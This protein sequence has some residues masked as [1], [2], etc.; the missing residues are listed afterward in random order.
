[1]TG[2]ALNKTERDTCDICGARMEKNGPYGDGIC[3]NCHEDLER[4]V[5]ERMRD[6]NPAP[7]M[8]RDDICG[9]LSYWEKRR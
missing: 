7:L 8:W 3:L 9:S 4:D 2:R 1:M 5:L 6:E